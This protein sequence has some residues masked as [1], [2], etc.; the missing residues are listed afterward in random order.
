MSHDNDD[1]DDNDEGIKMR[2]VTVLNNKYLDTVDSYAD[3]TSPRVSSGDPRKSRLQSMSEA[4]AT[5]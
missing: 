4:T 5:S 3:S 1:N 2:E